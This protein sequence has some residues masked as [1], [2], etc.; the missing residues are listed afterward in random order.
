M[1]EV[2]TP[3]QNGFIKGRSISDNLILASKLLT[4]IQK[5]KKRKK[6]WCALKLDIAKVYDKISWKFLEAI[7]G[8]MHFPSH[9]I[10]LIM[11]C[12]R[13]VSYSLLFNGQLAGSFIRHYGL[14]QGDPLS[15]Y[16]FI[17]CSNVLSCMLIKLQ[18]DKKI[19]GISFGNR[20]PAISHLMYADDVILFFQPTMASCQNVAQVLQRYSC[21]A[22]QEVN[23]SKSRIIFS[24]N[25]PRLHKWLMASTLV[26]IIL[27]P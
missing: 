12:V 8:L 27:R 11:S 26:S 20:G 7:L 9:W 5:N 3:F 10:Q 24:S 23:R 21:L 4:F 16:L 6:H 19:K 13:F 2:T 25:V 17:F 18:D 22:G 1:D 15:P 14:R